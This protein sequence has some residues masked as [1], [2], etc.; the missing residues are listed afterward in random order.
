L[1]EWSQQVSEDHCPGFAVG[2]FVA[3]TNENIIR[4][5]ITSS[6]HFQRLLVLVGLKKLCCMQSTLWC[7][8]RIQV[9]W[10][11]QVPGH[12]GLR[13][14]KTLMSLGIM[15]KIP[16]AFHPRKIPGTHFC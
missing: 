8:K 16:A 9:T 12:D 7:T 3:Q 2:M 4:D 10:P 11:Y 5:V 14:R 1:E 13:Y 15:Q 6:Q